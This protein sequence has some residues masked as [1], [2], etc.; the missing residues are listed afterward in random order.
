MTEETQSQPPENMQPPDPKPTKDTGKQ[1][2]EVQ[3]LA[4]VERPKPNVR[5]DEVNQSPETPPVEPHL[6][7]ELEDPEIMA[8]DIR[9]VVQDLEL[10]LRG[11][12]EFNRQ[13]STLAKRKGEI[14]KKMQA[15]SKRSAGLSK[16][17]LILEKTQKKG[18]SEAIKAFQQRSLEQRELKAKNAQA[19]IKAGTN[20]DAI[21]KM[22]N[23]KS[24]IDQGF[25]GRKGAHGSGRPGQRLPARI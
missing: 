20:P 24:P 17:Q 8:M 11:L 7:M 14:E 1:S 13:F 5:L 16:I 23:P 2:A 3:A 18:P 25:A 19:F 10:C 22:L 12:S 9:L 4:K 21:R 6:F 15:I